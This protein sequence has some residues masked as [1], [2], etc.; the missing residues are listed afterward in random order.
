MLGFCFKS[1]EIEKSKDPVFHRSTTCIS[2]ALTSGAAQSLCR[3]I[4]VNVPPLMYDH[5]PL[6]YAAAHLPFDV[7]PTIHIVCI[8]FGSRKTKHRWRMRKKHATRCFISHFVYPGYE[9]KM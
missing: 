5:A 7:A 8:G 2:L 9:R 6:M 1:N 4:K 3:S